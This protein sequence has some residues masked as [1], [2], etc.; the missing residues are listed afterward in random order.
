MI[1]ACNSSILCGLQLFW[2]YTELHSCY[3][4]R[5]SFF[6]GRGFR[7]ALPAHLQLRCESVNHFFPII[8]GEILLSKRKGIQ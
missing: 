3:G 6:T 4:M 8:A 1:Y 5:Y 7:I 2:F